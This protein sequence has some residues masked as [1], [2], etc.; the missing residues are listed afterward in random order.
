MPGGVPR[1]GRAGQRR[2]TEPVRTGTAPAYTPERRRRPVGD[3]LQAPSRGREALGVVP[4][5]H[6]ATKIPSPEALILVDR[7]RQF[8]GSAFVLTG[9]VRRSAG[10]AFV[11]TGPVRRSSGSAFVFV[12]LVR[13]SSGSAFV[14]V[15]LVRRSSGPAFVLT[16]PNRRSS[17]S[18]FVFTTLV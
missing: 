7:A 2:R 5:P 10:S 15:G 17:G 4:A 1:S 16:R 13:R 18:A 12:T 14:F 9:P 6:S 3:G 8:S 11:L